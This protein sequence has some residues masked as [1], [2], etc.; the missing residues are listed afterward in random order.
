[1]QSPVAPGPTPT[2]GSK[3]F[4]GLAKPMPPRGMR[5]AGGSR[6][7]VCPRDAPA[8]RGCRPGSASAPER[9]ERLMPSPDGVVRVAAV[10]DIHCTKASQGEL[11]PLFAQAAELA[12]VLVLCGDLTDY[13]LPEEA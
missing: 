5:L 3:R 6:A 1:M 4:G 13:G 7:S 2:R 9:R 8:R 10:G 11:R 12:D